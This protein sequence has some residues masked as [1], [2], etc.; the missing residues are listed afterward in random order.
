MERRR[1]GHKGRAGEDELDSGAVHC[2]V[3]K[4]QSQRLRVDFAVG[5]LPVFVG[6]LVGFVL[7]ESPGVDDSGAGLPAIQE[8]EMGAEEVYGIRLLC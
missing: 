3:P 7:R 2:V 1:L 6:E 4:L 8:I 5:H